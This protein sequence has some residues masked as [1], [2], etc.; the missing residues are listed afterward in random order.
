MHG[1][2]KIIFNKRNT[3]KVMQ[4]IL[5][6]LWFIYQL[7]SSSDYRRRHRS[8][9]VIKYEFIIQCVCGIQLFLFHEID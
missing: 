7:I 8:N 6:Y 3:F 4:V 1:K 9:V 2:L 5:F